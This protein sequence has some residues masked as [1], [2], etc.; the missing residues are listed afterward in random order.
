MNHV[1]IETG[2]RYQV[3]LEEM[4]SKSAAGTD[5][6]HVRE[7]RRLCRNAFVAV[8]DDYCRDQLQLIELYAAELFSEAAHQSWQRGPMSGVDVLKQNIIQCLGTFE[9]RLISIAFARRP[10]I[11]ELA[12]SQ[13]V[14]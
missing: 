14:N 11:E 1:D 9:A 7:A 3:A 6:H 5:V 8:E 13:A 10:A 2:R 12:E 4:F